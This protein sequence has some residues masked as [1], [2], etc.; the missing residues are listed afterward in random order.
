[1]PHSSMPG[2]FYPETSGRSLEDMEALF[3]PDYDPHSGLENERGSYHDEEDEEVDA[4]IPRAKG[5]EA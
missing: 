5:T 1:M 3:N 4:T 2:L